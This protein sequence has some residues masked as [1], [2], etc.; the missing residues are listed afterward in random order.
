MSTSRAR[1]AAI[2]RPMLPAKWHRIEKVTV[3][4]LGTLD[5]PRVFIDYTTISHDGVPAGQLVDGFEVALIS[6]LT[7]FARAED[8]LDAAAQQL[9]RRI[10]ASSEVAWS[11][12]DKRGFGDPHKYLGWVV[13]VQLLTPTTT[14]QE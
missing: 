6:N 8:D 7:D 4:S 3:K 9:V 1:L 5:G 13:S 11:T 10:D 2:L 12:A 14:T